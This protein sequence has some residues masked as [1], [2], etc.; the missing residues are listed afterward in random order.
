[1]RRRALQ[2]AVTALALAVLPRAALAQ[3]P[4]VPAGG[5]DLEKDVASSALDAPVIEAPPE[6]PPP[7]PYK[8]T[9][10]IDSSLGAMR[11]LGKFGET[12]PLAPW[13]HTQIGYEI[14]RWLMVFGEG[15][16]AFSDTSGTQE[17]PK[18]RAFPV[19]GFG[20]GVRLT[21]RFGP[22]IGVYLQGS[23]GAMKADIRTNA[24]A[25]IGFKNAE[26]LGLYA[27]GRLGVEYYMM[28]RHFALGLTSGL[29]DATG[30]KRTVGSDTP[31]AFDAGASLRYAF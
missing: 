21:A 7:P 18:T 16:L 30:F 15:E 9:L 11:F 10:V 20:G 17:P 19:L 1:M 4:G 2:A 14:F 12:A 8:K 26:S 28:D 22:R 13:I 3:E 23:V 29:K 25:I 24:L 5:I 31:L 27:G 6:S